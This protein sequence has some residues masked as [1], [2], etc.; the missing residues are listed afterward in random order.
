MDQ[1]TI[2]ALSCCLSDTVSYLRLLGGFLFSSMPS[3]CFRQQV[4]PEGLA[5]PANQLLLVLLRQFKACFMLSPSGSKVCYT[6]GVALSAA[7]LSL[8]RAPS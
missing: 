4:G 6:E 7:Q 3:S 5:V 8:F 2:S 1:Q